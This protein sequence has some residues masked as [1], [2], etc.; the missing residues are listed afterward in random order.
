MVQDYTKQTNKIKPL[1]TLKIMD[2]SHKHNTG[3]KKSHTKSTG[4]FTT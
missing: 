4:W 1:L 2:E 3:Q